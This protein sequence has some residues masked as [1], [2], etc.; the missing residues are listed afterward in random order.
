MTRVTPD[1]GAE[2]PSVQLQ[3]LWVTMLRRRAWSSLAVVPAD[4]G[5]SA[6]S[7][8][9]GLAALAEQH[10]RRRLTVVAPD[11][12]GSLDELPTFMPALAVQ[13]P[14]ERLEAS[15]WEIGLRESVRM[16]TQHPEL[17][18]LT[19][20]PSV[21]VALDPVA[22]NPLGIAVASA[23]DAVL[24]CISLGETTIGAAKQTVELIG[25]ERFIGCVVI[26][27]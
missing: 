16:R 24:L 19:R 2:I 15:A 13:E 5:G 8:A 7:T 3:Q 25:R 27:P 10:L 4:T 11:E 1:L 9:R 17:G 20:A 14:A 21:I 6:V 22:T 12:L 26:R 18:E 23:V